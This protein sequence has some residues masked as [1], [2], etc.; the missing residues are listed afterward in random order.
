MNMFVTL[1]NME[2]V[3]YGGLMFI[4]LMVLLLKAWLE[5]YVA[6]AADVAVFV[7]MFLIHGG[8]LTGGLSAAVTAMLFSIASFTFLRR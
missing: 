5:H 8:T 2:P 1:M 4:A 3:V 7:V 6:I